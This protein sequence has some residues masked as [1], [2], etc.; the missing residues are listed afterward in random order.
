MIAKQVMFKLIMEKR[1]EEIGK[2][3]KPKKTHLRP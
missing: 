3:K 2:A 1:S